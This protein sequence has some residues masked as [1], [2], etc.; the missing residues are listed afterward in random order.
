MN[1]EGKADKFVRDTVEMDCLLKES[2]WFLIIR[3]FMCLVNKL[4][5]EGEESK[6]LNKELF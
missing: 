4:T 5:L 1:I 2:H 3:L 6:I